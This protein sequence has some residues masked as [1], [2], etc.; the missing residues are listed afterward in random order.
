[1]P[2]IWLFMKIFTLFFNFIFFCLLA[3]QAPAWSFEA[4]VIGVSDGDTITVLDAQKNQHKIRLAGIDAPEKAQDYGNRSKQNLSQLV[5]GKKV[6]IPDN[7]KDRYG[8]TVSRVMVNGTD[9]GLEQI[10]AGFAW[11]YKKYQK[12]QLPRDRILYAQA[13]DQSQVARVGLWAMANPIEPES[14][15]RNEAGTRTVGSSSW[16]N[17]NPIDKLLNN[18]PCSSDQLC[19]GPKGGRYCLQANGKKQYQSN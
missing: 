8:R 9:A 15:R 13:Q 14:F 11:H 7:I 18:C 16:F 1:M 6:F 3:L 5:F 2:F 12:D 10:K 4:I 17:I 19:T